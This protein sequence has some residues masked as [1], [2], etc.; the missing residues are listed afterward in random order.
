MNTVF[1]VEI[2]RFRESGQDPAPP[3][4]QGFTRDIS[5]GGMCIEV[6]S[7]G[8]EVEDLIAAPG[9]Y[10]SLAID[11][12]FSKHPILAV[13]RVAWLRKQSQTLPAR[14]LIGVA[15]TQID[16]KAKRRLFK[17]AKRLVWVPRLTAVAGLV[18]IALLAGLF[19]N[20][21]K[22]ILE[23][24]TLVNRWVEGA[25]ERSA[26]SSELYEL[27]KRRS[28]LEAKLKK[29][30]SKIKEQD[31][32]RELTA[33][34]GSTQELE[35]TYRT[36]RETEKLTATAALRQ[37]ADWIRTHQNLR[38]GLVAS[39]EGDTELEDWAFTYDQSLACQTYLLFGD[40]ENARRILSFYA[41]RAERE[42]GAYFNA[43]HAG[44]GGP[45]ERMI[46]AGPNLWIGIAALQYE[47]KVKDGQ[48]LGIAASVADWVI[49]MQDEEGGLKGGPAFDWYST[50]HNLD[51]HA[52]L[53]MMAEVTGDRRY[54]VAS[55]KALEWIKKYA[56]SVKERRMNRGK[57]DATIATDTFSWAIAAV[58]PEKLAAI[59][60]D[61]EAI[62]QFA[63]EHCEVSVNYKDPRGR[64][65]QARGFDFAKAQNIGRGGVISTEWTAQMIVTYRILS[66]HFRETGDAGR[67]ELYSKKADLYL[68]ELQKLII[69]SPS[70]TG[71][72]RGC[73][74]YASIDNV[75]TGHGWRT[76]RGPRT[77]SVSGTAYGIFA[78][79][80]YNPFDLE[81]KKVVQ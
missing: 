24:K 7:A 15:Y 58:G 41:S 43:Y 8:L 66:D 76:P 60:L 23:N 55:E 63:E 38:T 45:L 3:L 20:N 12:P 39:F 6:K 18:M 51:A 47:S 50:E 9:A 27:E 33:L 53:R 72:G 64:I 4:L 68:N 48:F 26:V 54:K 13:A 35:A 11:P 34:K 77:G 37:M 22:L 61:P 67:A 1:P 19:V 17:Y 75:D 69:T 56:Y 14:Y 81:N 62:I 70:R 10:L 52:F 65:T 25:A 79:V 71:Q 5:A 80:G 42:E 21:Q 2:S 46:H 57:G 31:I 16:E 73:L 28:V 40:L 74:P 36:L 59:G 32:A 78:W 44:D 49:R 29:A 30:E